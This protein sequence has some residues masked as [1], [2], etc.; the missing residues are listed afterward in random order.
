MRI[1]YA[2]FLIACRQQLTSGWNQLEEARKL[3]PNMSFRFS[4]F[5]WDQE[6]KQKAASS[7]SGNNTATDLVSYVEFQKN[8]KNLL[9]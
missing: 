3:H 7:S 1:V 9:M 2:N 4:I 6:H 5:T 8:Y